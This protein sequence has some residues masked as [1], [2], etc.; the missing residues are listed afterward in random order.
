MTST[1]LALVFADGIVG[2][3]Q[4]VE[5]V[6]DEQVQEMLDKTVF[7]RGAPVSW[8]RASLSDFPTDHGDFRNAWKDDGKSISV[9][10]DKAKELTRERLRRERKPLLD[11][12]DIEAMRAIEAGDSGKLGEVTADKQRLRDITALPEIDSAKT[13]DDLRAISVGAK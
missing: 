4:F 1:V 8:R 3:T 2:R 9:D 5:E 12:L 11:A 10:M 6:S 13:P 7:K